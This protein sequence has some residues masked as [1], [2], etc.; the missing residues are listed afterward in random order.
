MS[1]LEVRG[2]EVSYGAISALRGVDMNAHGGEI[3]A[4]LGANGAGKSTLLKTIAGFL[5]ARSGSITLAGEELG[6]LSVEQ[7][8]RGGIAL[9]PEG[10]QVWP[11]LS[12]DDH[13]RLGWFGPRGDRRQYTTRRDVIYELF[14]RLYERRGQRAG[15][16]SGG[17]QQMLAIGRAL[18]L[19]PR[20]LLLDE[21]TLGLAPVVNDR[22]AEALQSARSADRAVVVAEQNAEFA[23][24]VADRG[25]VLEVGEVKTEGATAELAANPELLSAYLG[26][27]IEPVAEQPVVGPAK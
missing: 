26:V 5:R 12:V 2:L 14:P 3:V 1:V 10:R 16:L 17:E 25:Y 27:A 19:E 7:R 23:F 20:I 18:I 15:T 21:P 6:G 22:I 24:D 4:V 9:V 13:L 11:E 8:V